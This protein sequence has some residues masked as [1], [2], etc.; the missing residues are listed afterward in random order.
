MLHCNAIDIA[1]VT[2]SDGPLGGDI[3]PI[4]DD[5][6]RVTFISALT[7]A[8]ALA[9]MSV[10]PTAAQTEV[11][12]G[13]DGPSAA[14]A[15]IVTGILSYTRWPA[16]EGPVRLCLAGQSATIPRIVDRALLSGRWLV[17]SRHAAGALPDGG[18]DAIFMA[19]LPM[20]EQERVARAA[21][22]SAVVTM[23]DADPQCD[24]GVMAC[25]RLVPGGMIFDLNLDAVSR[26]A[27]RIDPRV[28][29]LATRG[30]RRP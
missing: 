15:D 9:A 13:I 29:M 18:C 14:A 16:D 3:V 17:V 24:S 20:R 5:N 7:G 10:M 25:L 4:L 6:R 22:G 19:G 1:T 21:Q 30:G 28:L 12:A 8:A 11:P 2:F 23:T 26:S 27:V